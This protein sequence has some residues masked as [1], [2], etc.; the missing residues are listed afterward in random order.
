MELAK[1]LHET[2]TGVKDDSLLAPDFRWAMHGAVQPHM[3]IYTNA[4]RILWDRRAA[5]AALTADLPATGSSSPSSAWP[6]RCACAALPAL[7]KGAPPALYAS[8][9]FSCAEVHRLCIRR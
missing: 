4:V 1:T 8:Q 9:Q 3:M 6:G 7:L 2:G 5:N